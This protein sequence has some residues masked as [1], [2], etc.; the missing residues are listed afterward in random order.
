MFYPI[1][2]NQK[3]TKPFVILKLKRLFRIGRKKSGG[4]YF[5]SSSCYLVNLA[6]SQAT[7]KLKKKKNM[8]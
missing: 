8:L 1:N 6:T 4:V 3:E 5:L 7:V 2:K